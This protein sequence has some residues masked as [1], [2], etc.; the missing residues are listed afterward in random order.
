MATSAT[1][2]RVTACSESSV[3][4]IALSFHAMGIPAEL[5]RFFG[6]ERSE[7]RDD[8]MPAEECR[9]TV[10]SCHRRI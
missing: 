6:E 5:H 8:A 9:A 4:R 1:A 3:G 2:L 7:Y 10:D